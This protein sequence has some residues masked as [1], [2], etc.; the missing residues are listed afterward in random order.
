MQKEYREEATE[1][2]ASDEDTD[3]VPELVT[4]RED[5]DSMVNEFLQNYEILGKKMKPKLDG[6]TPIDKLDTIR[7]A[8]RQVR[9]NDDADDEMHD[10]ISL[11]DMFQEDRW[12][13]ET[14]LSM[15][16]FKF[17]FHECSNSSLSNPL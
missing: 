11:E 14:I 2:L 4:L 6:D 15:Y 17:S 3:E 1:Q 9:I 8:L 5:F 12:D 7:N 13:C 16:L 10:I